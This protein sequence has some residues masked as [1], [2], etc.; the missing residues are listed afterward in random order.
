MIVS[1]A[2]GAHDMDN[3]LLKVPLPATALIVKMT[4]T[5]GRILRL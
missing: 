5:M 1:A 2:L 3:T 4:L